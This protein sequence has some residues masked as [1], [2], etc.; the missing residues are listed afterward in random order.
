MPWSDSEY[1]TN[2]ISYIFIQPKVIWRLIDAMLAT[3]EEVH[4]WVVILQCLYGFMS[5]DLSE[6][7]DRESGSVRASRSQKPE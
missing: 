7:L 1:A 3:R 6:N 5:A 4:V 2:F